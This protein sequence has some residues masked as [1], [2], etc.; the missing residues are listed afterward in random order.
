MNAHETRSTNP[1]ATASG[2]CCGSAHAHSHDEVSQDRKTQAGD[3]GCCTPKTADAGT[4]AAK[5]KPARGSG[6]CCS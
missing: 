1:P 3:V 4:P 5:P 2:G 6:C